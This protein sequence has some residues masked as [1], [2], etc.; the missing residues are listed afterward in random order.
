MDLSRHQYFAAQ[1]Q[2][3]AAGMRAEEYLRLL[4]PSGS[5]GSATLMRLDD[6]V[7]CARTY[8]PDALPFAASV[9]LDVSAY[10]SLHRY[11]GPRSGG[12]LAALNV[13]A[14]DLD[15]RN[16]PQLRRAKPGQVAFAVKM[17]AR[18]HDLPLPSIITDTGRGLAV[19]WLINELPAVAEARWRAAQACLIELFSAY[20]ADRSCSDAARIFRLPETTNLKNGRQVAVVDGTLQRYE[21][22]ALADLIYVAAGRPTRVELV[23]RKGAQR[24]R[25]KHRATGA[26]GLAP[27]ARFRQV[28]ADL[29]ALASHWG[30]QVPEGLRNTWLHL[31]ATCIT[32]QHGTVDVADF[33]ESAAARHC[34]GLPRSEVAGVVRA[35][36]RR[37][38]GEQERYYYAG[39]RM[40]EMLGVSDALARRLKLK[41]IL[42]EVERARRRLE[43]EA[44]RRRAKG[45]VPR[46]EY[47]AA[48]AISRD[49]PWEAHG[50][51][52]A[53]WYRRGCPPPPVEKTTLPARQETCALRE[54]PPRP[55][56]GGLPRRRP[57]REL[58]AGHQ[59]LH[60]QPEATQSRRPRPARPIPMRADPGRGPPNRLPDL[61]P[62]AD[63]IALA[64]E[65]FPG[66]MPAPV[67]LAAAR[68]P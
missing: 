23:T 52:R 33:V 68:S 66:C 65:M 45:I 5:F 24:R 18:D 29:G 49:K 67:P 25:N 28:R 64:E 3:A 38:S 21:F 59:A 44:S 16:M 19:L 7:R 31:L 26:R 40:A 15:Y 37:Q 17:A 2:P 20:G 34:A 54:T 46:E 42:S 36:E 30:G 61:M 32:H 8:R 62:S 6:D 14:L 9:W 22:D 1:T 53:T 39:A 41:Q 27:A 57:R 11:Y 58:S 63:E 47:L 55:L 50:Y 13:L 12:R 35:A 48:H 43:R 10:V 51:S 4:H 60:P 56:Q